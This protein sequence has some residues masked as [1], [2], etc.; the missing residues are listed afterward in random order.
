[1]LLTLIL[2]AGAALAVAVLSLVVAVLSRRRQAA[3]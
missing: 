2:L 1:M 3:R